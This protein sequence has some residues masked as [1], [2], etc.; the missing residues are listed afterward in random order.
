MLV[1]PVRMFRSLILASALGAA[2][3]LPAAERDPTWA[4]KI[5]QPGL[6]NL[7]RVAPNLYR[8]AQ[9]TAGGFQAA[10]KLG[11]KTVINLRAWHSD[12][13]EAAGTKLRIEHIRFKTWHPEDEEVVR[14][15]QIVTRRGHG[16]WL[17]HCQHGADRTGT[18]IAIYRIAVQ[19]WKKDDAIREMTSGGFGYHAIWSNLI[20]Y[21]RALDIDALK[22]KAGIGG[23][24]R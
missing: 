22:K 7:H 6:P 23:S 24:A 21:L 9:P 4:A 11:V 20:R 13:E 3:T 15:L 18:M 1:Q 19:G 14:F 17:V 8:S 5:E 12:D 2:G 16:P 10:E